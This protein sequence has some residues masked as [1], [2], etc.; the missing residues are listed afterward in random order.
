VGPPLHWRSSTGAIR[1]RRRQARSTSASPPHS[2][3]PTPRCHSPSCVP[4]VA[5]APPRSM[6]GSPCSPIP[7]ASSKPTTD[8]ASPTADPGT[9]HNHN[10]TGVN[11]LTS[12]FPFAVSSTACGN[13]NWEVDAIGGYRGRRRATG[14]SQ[15][16]TF[17]CSAHAEHSLVPAARSERR[18][19]QR[20]SRMA[21]TLTSPLAPPLPGHSL[22]AASTT[23][24]SR[25]TGTPDHTRTPVP[26]LPSPQAHRKTRSC[27]V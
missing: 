25:G 26:Q 5:S 22:P 14:R 24:P 1:Q 4:A 11:A 15:T 9:R 6:S 3:V 23:A 10:A 12:Q 17:S 2:L 8:I 7:V 18:R 21:G 20:P 19:A 13:G 16:I 27:L